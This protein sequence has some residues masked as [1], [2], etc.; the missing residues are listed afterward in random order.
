MVGTWYSV[1]NNTTEEI[2][3]FEDGTLARC[4]YEWSTTAWIYYGEYTEKPHYSLE[5]S[6][7]RIHERVE[8]YSQN[9]LFLNIEPDSYYSEYVVEFGT[10]GESSLE[11]D[12]NHET[13]TIRPITSY[14][15]VVNLITGEITKEIVLG[16]G[17]PYLKW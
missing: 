6:G 10:Y 15:D 13:I 12:P 17:T 9:N 2:R 8:L 3:F 11:I 1:G 14:D 5:T 7:P 16:S 4:S